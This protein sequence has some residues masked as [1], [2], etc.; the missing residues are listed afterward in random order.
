MWE[1]CIKLSPFSVVFPPKWENTRVQEGKGPE[2]CSQQN[3]K[4]RQDMLFTGLD[5]ASL[6]TLEDLS[7]PS[8]VMERELDSKVGT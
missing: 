5:K 4:K 6:Y 7:V 1:R 2:G 3:W 8:P